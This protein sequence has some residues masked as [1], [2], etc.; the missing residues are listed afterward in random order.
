L[1]DVLF[2]SFLF[3]GIERM[4]IVPGF[5]QYNPYVLYFMPYTHS[6]VAAAGWS[7]ISGG[8]WLVGRRRW[9]EAAVIAGAVFSHF[10]LD[11]PV[12]TAD[13]PLLG[14]NSTKIG[15]GLWNHWP[16]ALAL[17]LVTLLVGWAVW[18]YVRGAADRPRAPEI[19]F[20]V[21]LVVLAVATPF[22][23][24]PPSPAA[25]GVQAL[26]SYGLLAII[27]QVI[28]RKRTAYGAA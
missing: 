15:L 18:V 3:V 1:L 16:W 23:P 17:E 4:R 20:F 7:A 14:N 24:P 5:T 26:V 13:M 11:V 2:A 12:H 28:D 21:A 6:L 10:V 22:F 25:F 19:V 9:R 8:A 27:A